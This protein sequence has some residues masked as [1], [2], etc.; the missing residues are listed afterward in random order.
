M[1]F[2]EETQTICKG[3]TC[4]MFLKTLAQNKVTKASEK[5]E[6]GSSACVDACQHR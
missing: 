3:V 4:L 6:N 5:S 1:F 2:K